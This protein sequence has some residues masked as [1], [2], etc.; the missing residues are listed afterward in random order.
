MHAPASQAPAPASPIP[1]AAWSWGAFVTG[2]LAL[3]G[4]VVHL[5]SGWN[6]KDFAL[7]GTGLDDRL[8]ALGSTLGSATLLLFVAAMFGDSGATRRWAFLGAAA[9]ALA[10]VCNAG[11]EQHVFTSL[12]DAF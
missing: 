10:I 1:G 8:V 7:S 3:V 11:F 9:Y 4:A 5:V 6:A 2:G 12:R